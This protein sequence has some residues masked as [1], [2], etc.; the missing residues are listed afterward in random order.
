LSSRL[1]SKNVKFVIYKTII[2]PVVVYGCETLSLILRKIHRLEVFENRV[3]RRIS[4]AKRDKMVGG[5]RKLHTRNF[6]TCASIIIRMIK[7]RM[8]RWTGDVARMGENMNARRILMG[9]PEGMRPL[10]RPRRKWGII[11]KLILGI[12]WGMGYGQDSSGV[13]EGTM[14]GSCEHG[15][16]PS[17]S[18]KCLE[19]LE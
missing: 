13:G 4:G 14:E 11:L 8:I 2:S 16:E 1:L 9:K 5:W 19:I 12:G 18:I 10:G 7:S 3:L 15:N 17:G 6:I